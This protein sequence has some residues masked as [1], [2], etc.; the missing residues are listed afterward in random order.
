MNRTVPAAI[1]GIH[2]VTCI[3]GDVQKCVDFYVAVLGLRFVKKSINQDLPD[4]YHI[5]FGDYTGGPGTAM[6]FF[7]WPTWPKRRTGSGQVTSVGFTVPAESIDFWTK[8]LGQLAVDITRSTR[9]GAD[10]IAL[11]DPDGIELNLVAGISPLKL[12]PWSD[13]PV[14]EANSI[15]GFHSVTLTVAEAAQTVELLEATMGF[16][17]S[18]Q[19]GEDRRVRL[20]TGGGGPHA[21]VDVLESPEGPVGEESIGTVHHVAWRTADAPSQL[22]WREKLVEAGRNVTPVIDRWYFKSIYYREPGGVLY[23]IATDGPGFTV[24]EKPEN[25]GK[26]LSLPPWFQVRREH[27]DESLTPIVVPTDLIKGRVY[28]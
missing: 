13:G 23:E 21:I 25:L 6:T 17:A 18:G 9:F 24:D 1:P 2:H 5:Y 3:T 8:R 15:H 12:T 11:H 7:G 27:L 19:D 16:R 22:A 10:V 14:P 26:T 4:T 20:T 28:S